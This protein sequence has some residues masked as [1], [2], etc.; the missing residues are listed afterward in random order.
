MPQTC[1]VVSRGVRGLPAIAE[2]D[3]VSVIA[4]LVYSLSVLLLQQWC[5]PGESRDP[6]APAFV[7]KD[8]I[9]RLCVTTTAG[10]CRPRFRGNDTG[11]TC[12]VQPPLLTC[13]LLDARDQLV[14]GLLDRHLL[15]DHAVHRLG[16]DVL[17]VE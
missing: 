15:A 11:V 12:T 6:Y 14:D 2:S 1:G 13:D 17:I 5:R 16:P 7:L 3:A 9:D 8:A 4:M 10:E